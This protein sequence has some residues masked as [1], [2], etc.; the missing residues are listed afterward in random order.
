MSSIPAATIDPSKRLDLYSR[1]KRVGSKKFIFL[2]STGDPVDITSFGFQFKVYAF[3]GAY[4]TR[5]SFAVGTGLTISGS[6]NNELTVSF[7]AANLNMKEGEYFYELYKSSTQKTYITGNF[8]LNL[9]VFDGVDSDTTT[10]TIDDSG[11]IEIT[12]VDSGSGSGGGGSWGSIVG[13]ITDQTDLIAYIASL[14]NEFE[15]KEKTASHTLDAQD[16]ADIIAGKRLLFLMNVAGAN[17]FTVPPQVSLA[18][19]IEKEFSVIRIGS[20]QT[21]FVEGSGVNFSESGGAADPGQNAPVTFIQTSINQWQ[22]CNGL[23]GG[24]T[25]DVVGPSSATDNAVALFNGTTGKLIKNSTLVPT[26][27]GT[28]MINAADAAAQT[29][30]LNVFTDLLKGLAPASGGGTT[31][32]LRADGTW[33]TPP[34]TGGTG[35]T[36]VVLGI[37]GAA[38]TLTN[39]PNG[40][41]ELSNARTNRTKFDATGFARVRLVATVRTAAANGSPLGNSPPRVYIKYSTDDSTYITVGSGTGTETCSLLAT[42]QFASDWITMPVGALADV[43]WQVVSIGGNSTDDPILG[44]VNIQFSTT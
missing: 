1:V 4:Q 32:Y 21:T 3:A 24:G 26:A 7:T 30:L 16:L 15:V 10:L 42:G 9:G 2:D 43:F 18:I 38:L 31:N 12:V 44:V 5:L 14:T 19:P 20:G 17:T 13:T 25:G 22:L 40:E 37:S 39:I 35:A 41:Q 36:K 28:S 29:A 27:A 33:G 23:S 34:G 8:I 11:V 6:G